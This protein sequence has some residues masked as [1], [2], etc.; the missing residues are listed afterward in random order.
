MSADFGG[1]SLDPDPDD[2]EQIGRDENEEDQPRWHLRNADPN[3]PSAY[4][5]NFDGNF[6]ESPNS[7]ELS[8]YGAN[9]AFFEEAP[10]FGRNHDVLAQ[11]LPI[12]SKESDGVPIQEALNPVSYSFSFGDGTYDITEQRR[13]QRAIYEPYNT[14]LTQPPQGPLHP[15]QPFTNQPQDI[16]IDDSLSFP[17]FSMD[18]RRAGSAMGSASVT[19]SIHNR[20]DHPLGVSSLPIFFFDTHYLHSN[21]RSIYQHEE[22]DLDRK[23]PAQQVPNQQSLVTQEFQERHALRRSHRKPPPAASRLV[24][25]AQPIAVTRQRSRADIFQ[26]HRKQRAN[27]P[28]QTVTGSGERTSERK[29]KPSADELA[30]A[31]TQRKAA[32]LKTWYERLN[33]LYRYK[34]EHGDSK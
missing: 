19:R 1:S 14:A 29:M 25:G 27:K 11:D 10:S 31:T 24:G 13:M 18:E 30:E 15:Q 3:T 5:P 32:A 28:Y 23:L 34:E 20:Y 22:S 6:F 16:R 8:Y 4:E 21:R 9:S 12:D 26:D 7:I 2:S 33:D 17:E